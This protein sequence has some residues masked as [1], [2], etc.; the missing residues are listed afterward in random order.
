MLIVTVIWY[1]L[2]GCFSAILSGE[3]LCDTSTSILSLTVSVPIWTQK[4]LLI[5]VP[6]CS[7]GFAHVISWAWNGIKPSSETCLPDLGFCRGSVSGTKA[8]QA[9]Q[10]WAKLCRHTWYVHNLTLVSVFQFNLPP[11][12]YQNPDNLVLFFQI[13]TLQRHLVNG[14]R[15]RGKFA[16]SLKKF[17]GFYLWFVGIFFSFPRTS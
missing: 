2:I 4:L 1:R 15:G 13:P 7:K 9:C 5:S 11:Y 3:K 6:H 10:V 12:V 14:T 8:E 16:S 17:C